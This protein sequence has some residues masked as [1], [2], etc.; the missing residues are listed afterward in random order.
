[1]PDSNPM[2]PDC[3]RNNGKSLCPEKH[4]I[5]R[6]RERLARALRYSFDGPSIRY[7]LVQALRDVFLQQT[8]E[9]CREES[10]PGN[11]IPDLAAAESLKLVGVTVKR[12]TWL[13]SLPRFLIDQGSEVTESL[14]LLNSFNYTRIL[15]ENTS[16]ASP[17]DRSPR[18]LRRCTRTPMHKRDEQAKEYL[19]ATICEIKTALTARH[20]GRAALEK[21]TSNSETMKATSNARRANLSL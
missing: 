19:Q 16:P 20:N 1:M 6:L 14:K 17:E 7:Q 4:M 8:Q 18:G 3:S 10:Q 12:R 15:S 11:S 2:P 13:C 9:Q 5:D 21:G